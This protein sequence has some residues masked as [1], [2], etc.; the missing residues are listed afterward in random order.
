MIVVGFLLEMD[1]EEIPA[2]N[3]PNVEE[4]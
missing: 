2:E 1:T 3:S 4:N